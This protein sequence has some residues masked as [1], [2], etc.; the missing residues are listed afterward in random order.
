MEMGARSDP[1]EIKTNLGQKKACFLLKQ[2]MGGYCPARAV[3]AHIPFPLQGWMTA[4]RR[5]DFQ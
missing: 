4:A 1:A 3:S 2:A 5:A